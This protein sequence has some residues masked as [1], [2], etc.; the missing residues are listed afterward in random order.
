[1]HGN[2]QMPIGFG[3]FQVIEILDG[4]PTGWPDDDIPRGI[5]AADHPKR[6]GNDWIPFFGSELVVCLVQ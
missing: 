5:R 1:M 6:L 2:D 3:Q 4:V